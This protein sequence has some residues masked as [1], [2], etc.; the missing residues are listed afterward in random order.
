M[1]HLTDRE[2][3]IKLLRG[4]GKLAVDILKDSLVEQ[5]SLKPCPNHGAQYQKYVYV[6]KNENGLEFCCKGYG[7]NHAKVYT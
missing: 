1:R 7:S 4:D 2:E 3:F 5:D 6:R